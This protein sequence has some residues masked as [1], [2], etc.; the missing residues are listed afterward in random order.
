[1][2]KV[3]TDIL[4]EAQKKEFPKLIQF[5]HLGVMVGGTALALQLQHR[6]SYDFDIFLPKPLPK[7]LLQK[8]KAVFG[9]IQIIR[10]TQ[11]ELTFTISSGLKITFFEYPF[12]SLYPSVT[13]DSIKIA[14]WRDIA[15]DKSHTI[16]RR[17]QYRDYVDLF[18]IINTKKITLDWLIQ[19][20]IKKFGDLFSEKLFL[21]QLTY[22]DDLDIVTIEFLKDS[23]T[24]SE[25]KLFFKEITTNYIKEK[26]KYQ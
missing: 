22:L 17:A 25:I 15:L 7:N 23:Y 16:G 18:C 26:L 4:T 14:G 12:K 13:T 3:Y 2:S 6:R 20:T 21:E 11:E 1:M 10:H 9:S 8:I 19:N 24:A 5:S